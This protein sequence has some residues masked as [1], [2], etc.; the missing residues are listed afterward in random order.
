MPLLP[1]AYLT[2]QPL[3]R[4]EGLLDGQFVLARQFSKI[5]S[6]KSNSID[7]LKDPPM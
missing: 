5:T 6:I 4:I 3:Q 2:Q 7:F 1:T